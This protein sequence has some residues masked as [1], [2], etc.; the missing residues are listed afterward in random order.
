MIQIRKCPKCGHDLTDTTASTCP[1]CGARF[2]RAAGASV[3]IGALFQFAVGTTFMLVFRFPKFM[4]AGFGFFILVGTLIASWAKTRPIP[5]PT[6]RGPITR[7][8]LLRLLS[9]MIAIFG[10]AFVCF[11]LFGFVMFINN[12]NDWHRYEGQ[13]FHRSTFEVRQVYY[14]K[15]GK[16]GVDLYASGNVEGQKE[17]MSL[18]PY[19][20]P[21]LP[22]NQ[23]QL[24]ERIPVGAQIKIYLF[25]EMKGRSRIRVYTETPPAEDY[26]RTAMNAL[27]YGLTGL[28]L[29][30]IAIFVMTRLRQL[31]FA[32]PEV[33]QLRA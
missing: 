23:G 4:I 12:W 8:V 3:W 32:A 7:P 16:G 2:T 6:P 5:R 22:R 26:H 20:G 33:T 14:Q 24:E 15:V 10:F 27:N 11:L 19:I 21:P 31:C 28:V 9:V 25:P 29:S 30:G 1:L 17:W 13:P 18:R